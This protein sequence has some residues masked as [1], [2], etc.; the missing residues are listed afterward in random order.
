MLPP[1]EALVVMSFDLDEYRRSIRALLE[2][3][4][5]VNE[6]VWQQSAN[7]RAAQKEAVRVQ[8][9]FPLLSVLAPTRN[10]P[11]ETK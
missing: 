1:R 3:A 10:A 7:I 4:G 5:R 8:R 6:A 11:T 2:E 9:R